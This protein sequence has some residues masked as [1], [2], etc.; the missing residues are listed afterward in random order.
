MVTLAGGKALAFFRC[1]QA[2]RCDRLTVVEVDEVSS[3]QI[4]RECMPPTRPANVAQDV[5]PTTYTS[6]SQQGDARCVGNLLDGH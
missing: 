2:Q 1:R 4:N 3:N 5:I 6:V